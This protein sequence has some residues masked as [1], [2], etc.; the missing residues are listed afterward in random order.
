[1]NRVKRESSAV[2]TEIK[3]ETNLTQ[4]PETRSRKRVRADTI[5]NARRPASPSP[6][7]DEPKDEDE[8]SDSDEDEDDYS[9]TTTDPV[10]II[11]IMTPTVHRKFLLH[12]AATHPEVLSSLVD[13]NEDRL[14]THKAKVEHNKTVEITFTKQIKEIERF[15]NKARRRIAYISR[16]IYVGCPDPSQAKEDEINAVGHDLARNIKRVLSRIVGVVKHYTLFETKRNALEAVRGVF[17]YCLY[18]LGARNRMAV[19]GKTLLS[20]AR[21]RRQEEDWEPIPRLLT[22]RDLEGWYET[23]L[24]PLSRNILMEELERMWE[25]R[26]CVKERLD[27]WELDPQKRCEFP[28]GVF[29][30]EDDESVDG[31]ENE[32]AFIH[33]IQAFYR[34]S[35][36]A[37]W[38]RVGGKEF[39]GTDLLDFCLNPA[40]EKYLGTDCLASSVKAEQDDADISRHFPL[41]IKAEQDVSRQAVAPKKEEGISAP[42]TALRQIPAFKREESVVK[43][44]PVE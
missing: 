26:F 24:A 30:H 37:S 17:D 27:E 4:L 11:S 12:A 29:V 6:S 15:I 8:N 13:W 3:A 33:W 22:R 10:E 19:G 1:M 41:S 44:E 43:N 18:G 20:R 35:K 9:P 25:Q 31:W 28:R 40:W 42:R 5:G 16:S 39:L 2:K 21:A 34:T 32:P 38:L 23:I 7:P 36:E 14:A